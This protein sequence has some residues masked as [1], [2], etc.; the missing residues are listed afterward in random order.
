MFQCLLPELEQCGEDTRRI[1]KT[2]LEYSED[3]KRIYCRS[4]MIG[5]LDPSTA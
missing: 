2:F 5:L 3:I 1:A 4:V